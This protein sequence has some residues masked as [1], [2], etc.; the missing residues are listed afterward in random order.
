MLVKYQ[1]MGCRTNEYHSAEE[2]Q[3]HFQ[4][5][6][7]GQLAIA[8]AVLPHM[9][10]RRSGTIANIGSVAGWNGAPGMGY[11]CAS[12]A[13][14]AS[15]T[16]ALRREVAHLGVAVT[17]IEPG[18]FRTSVLAQATAA[19]TIADYEHSPASET[20]AEFRELDGRQPGDPAKGARR[21]VEMLT[22]TGGAVGGVLP[23]RFLLG[24]DA[25]AIMT[26]VS[27][28]FKDETDVWR[29]MSVGTDFD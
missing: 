18:H 1:R 29:S 19:R 10:S 21:I 22:G 2:C 13:A 28:R 6:V 9:R 11:Y 17:V 25:L 4:V 12:K 7:F 24:E 20:K 8:R 3:Q 27:G 14:L 15:L 5:N 23:G 16:L 26:V